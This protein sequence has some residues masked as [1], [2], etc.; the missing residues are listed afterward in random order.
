MR[1]GIFAKTFP[2]A[3]P[4]TAFSIATFADDV[5]ALIEHLQL[6]PVVLGGISMGAAISSRIAVHRPE[7]VRALILAMPAWVVEPAPDN[8]RPNLEVGELI[9]KLAPA[10]ARAAFAASDTYAV[11]ARQ[12]PDNLASLLG[13]FDREPSSVTA[14]LLTSISAD[15]PGITVGGLEQLSIPALI[16]ATDQDVVHP[17]SHAEH[18]AHLIPGSVFKT[19]TPKGVDKLAYITN[20]HA[21]LSAFLRDLCPC[22]A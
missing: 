6:P 21:A 5:A 15:G 16:L 11:L 17:T 13:F 2:G 3:D 20:F 4:A 8:M 1:L 22:P 19:M 9:A 18:L 14:A 7:L 12:A 10:D